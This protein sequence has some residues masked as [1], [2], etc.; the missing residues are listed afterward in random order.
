MTN[1][2]YRLN[3]G[4]RVK[5]MSEAK[6]SGQRYKVEYEPSPAFKTSTPGKYVGEFKGGRVQM[7]HPRIRKKE[8]E[9]W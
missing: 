4:T 3:D 7:R 2:F 9:K 8:N 5:T 1:L 6:A